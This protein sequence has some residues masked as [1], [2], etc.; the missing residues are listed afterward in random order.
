MPAASDGGMQLLTVTVTSGG[1]SE[2]LDFLKR[3]S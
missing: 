1:R 3:K 2:T